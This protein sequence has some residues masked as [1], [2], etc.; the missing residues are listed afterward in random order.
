MRPCATCCVNH[1][2][3][4]MVEPPR[5]YSPPS[6]RRRSSPSCQSSFFVFTWSSSGCSRPMVTTLL[7]GL[8]MVLTLF[9]F[10]YMFET[11]TSTTTTT[12]TR[13]N[14]DYSN[15][16]APLPP[17]PLPFLEI[18]RRLPQA[19]SALTT[20]PPPQQEQEQQQQKE[21]EEYPF[22]NRTSLAITITT[23][24]TRSHL[25][26]NASQMA[27]AANPIKGSNDKKKNNTTMDHV[28]QLQRILTLIRSMAYYNQTSPLHWD[29]IREH[30]TYVDAPQSLFCLPWAINSDVW[31]TH[32]PDWIY[33]NETETE[34]CFQ[35]ILHRPKRTL[36][37]ELYQKQFVTND[38]N[39]KN[40]NYHVNCSNV[41]TSK[42][43]SSGWGAD[44]NELTNALNVAHA[45]HRPM[46]VHNR[47]WH[48][49][50]PDQAHKGNP[51]KPSP[52]ACPKMTMFCY[53][54]DLSN[55]PPRNEEGGSSGGGGGGVDNHNNDRP[56]QPPYYWDRYDFNDEYD[57]RPEAFLYMTTQ[58]RAWVREYLTR[59]QTW[60]RKR[61]FDLVHLATTRETEQDNQTTTL[62]NHSNKKSDIK[63]RLMNGPLKTPCTALHV[64]RSDVVDHGKFSRRYH[65]ISEYLNQT[66]ANLD[67]HTETS[68]SSSSSSPRFVIHPNLL[69]F[70]DDHNAITEPLTEYPDHYWMY[71][72]RPRWQGLQGGWEHQLPSSDPILEMTLLLA[73][74]RLVTFCDSLVYSHSGFGRLL[75]MEL[76]DASQRRRHQQPYS[77]NTN[78]ANPRSNRTSTAAMSWNIDQGKGSL[79]SSDYRDT[80]LV[81]QRYDN[82]SLV[83]VAAS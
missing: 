72:N 20:P 51:G 48:Y 13:L 65:A 45:Y 63:V 64:R 11:T 83:D 56:R 19:T 33:T 25:V 6:S 26:Q 36:F 49:A 14:L 66:Q 21:Q 7:V 4:Q 73:T 2:S 16:N 43:V 35:P 59:P 50:A 80:V 54:L 12:A 22:P 70:T 78:T 23:T 37:L 44:I 15:P 17:P 57:K 46:Q 68:S 60:L 9:Q 67:L 47:P 77:Y 76:S 55:C 62:A 3:Q 79:E 40:N 52:P 41:F 69:L 71:W 8:L 5:R 27:A 32:H 28:Q 58:R 61:V 31:W 29:T 81:S 24:G 74:F 10:H 42:M 1:H 39:D 53:F 75:A 34:Y 82:V 18:Q 38:D 30:V